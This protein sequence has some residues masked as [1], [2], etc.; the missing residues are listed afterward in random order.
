MLKKGK[1]TVPGQF[2][3]PFLTESI[4]MQHIS[5]SYRIQ[6]EVRRPESHVVNFYR[7]EIFALHWTLA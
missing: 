4:L 1:W 6:G 2:R 3:F 7:I 5:Y